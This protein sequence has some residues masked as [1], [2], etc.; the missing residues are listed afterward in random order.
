METEKAS[1]RKPE[2]KEGKRLFDNM[3]KEHRPVSL[4]SISHINIQ[5]NDTV[6]DIGC[7]SGLNVKRL[8]EKSSKAK[9]YGIDYSSTS[10]ETAKTLNREEVKQGSVDIIKANVQE[11]P[12][13]DERFDI[14]TAFETVYF[15]PTIVES[16]REVKRILKPQGQFCIIMDANGIYD[17]ELKE[18]EKQENCKFYTDEE[19]TIYLKEAG[20]SKITIYNRKRKNDKLIIKRFYENKVTEEVVDED[21]NDNYH[22][23]RLVTPEWLCIISEK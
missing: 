2:G 18:I 15:W 22:E 17:D 10:V 8:H 6:L 1:Y 5:E 9:T 19:L 7:G 3:D 21:I 16:F 20:F 11:M 13:E 12:F 14:V 23:G 4:W